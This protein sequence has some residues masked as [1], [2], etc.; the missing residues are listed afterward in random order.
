MKR[1]L[2]LLTV[3]LA[4]L[5]GCGGHKLPQ[6]AADLSNVPEIEDFTDSFAHV[7]IRGVE[8]DYATYGSLTPDAYPEEYQRGP[9]YSYFIND[10]H[11]VYFCEIEGLDPKQW[12]VK[13][14]DDGYG[15]FNESGNIIKALDVTEIP[16]WIE[17]IATT[18]E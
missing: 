12:L 6:P 15:H 14:T 2:M 4:I 17:A 3:L 8:Y 16:T 9:V 11:Y 10:D 18:P 7:I 13:L 1:T 5:T